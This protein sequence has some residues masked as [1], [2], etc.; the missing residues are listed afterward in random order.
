MTLFDDATFD[1]GFC[2]TGFDPEALGLDLCAE[3]CLELVARRIGYGPDTLPVGEKAGRIK[4]VIAQGIEAVALAG[5]GKPVTIDR[6]SGKEVVAGPVCVQSPRWSHVV[7]Q[8]QEPQ[9]LYGFILTLGRDFDRVKEKAALFDAYVLDALG[10]EMVEQAADRVEQRIRAWCATRNR[11]CSR[12]F[13]P[14]YCDWPLAQGQQAL[15]DF[16]APAAIGVKVLASGAMVPS[17]SITGAVIMARS[18]PLSCPCPVCNQ[19]N[20]AYRRVA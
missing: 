6:W 7:R 10:S 13:S 17:K 5:Q 11:V 8:A 16:L 19:A 3:N 20:C 18:L 9:A 4:T 2:F 15:G 12:R 1:A 14:G